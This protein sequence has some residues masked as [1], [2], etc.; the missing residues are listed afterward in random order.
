MTVTIEHPVSQNIF[1]TEFDYACWYIN[2]ANRCSDTEFWWT[3]I[4]L[5]K[6]QTSTSAYACIE[7]RAEQGNGYCVPGY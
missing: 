5:A 6:G 2:G 1:W 4:Y 3:D 7:D